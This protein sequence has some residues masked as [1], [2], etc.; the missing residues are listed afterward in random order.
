MRRRRYPI[1]EYVPLVWDGDG[2]P[3]GYYVSGHVTE[4]EF[5]A[6]IERWFGTSNRKPAI[7]PDAVIEHVTVVSVRVGNDDY[8]NRAYEWRHV[9]GRGRPMTYWEVAPSR[10]T[11]A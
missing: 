10:A 3:C 9:V 4:A 2:E 8:G 6:E 5:R 7:P 11:G 1:G